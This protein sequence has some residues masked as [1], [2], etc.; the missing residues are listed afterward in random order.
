[1]KDLIKREDVSTM[2]RSYFREEM[3][4]EMDACSEY[5]IEFGKISH[6]L[7][8][9]KV[10]QARLRDVPKSDLKVVLNG[11]WIPTHKHIWAKN[12]D[13]AIDEWAWWNKEHCNGPICEVCGET[14][15][16]NCTPNWNETKC[17]KIS[18]ECSECGNHVK[19]KTDY[20]SKCG[21]YMKEGK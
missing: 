7:T 3:E 9:N 2:I 14:P 19:E 5:E 8:G 12:E 6:L 18:Y 1:M 11:R 15:C 16:V 10:L 17:K 13:G 21:V 20:C 4:K